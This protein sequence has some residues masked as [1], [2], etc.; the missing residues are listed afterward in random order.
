[1]FIGPI[2]VWQLFFMDKN[3]YFMYTKRFTT[4]VYAHNCCTVKS[5]CTLYVS[6]AAEG[7]EL[8]KLRRR[9]RGRTCVDGMLRKRREC[10]GADDE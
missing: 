6:K 8:I 3:D 4:F 1:M 9:N 2:V 10:V 7:D 5:H